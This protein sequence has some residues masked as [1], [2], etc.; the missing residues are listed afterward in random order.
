MIHLASM[1][2]LRQVVND[3]EKEENLCSTLHEV[4]FF[5]ARD[6]FSGK[7]EGETSS[8]YS[9]RLKSCMNVS[10]CESGSELAW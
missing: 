10:S 8:W 5:G 2:K 6:V 9:S 7:S 1:K 4:L 3:E